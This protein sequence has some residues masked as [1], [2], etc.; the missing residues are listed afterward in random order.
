M[1]D[2]RKYKNPSVGAVLLD[3]YAL[4]T[5]Q[6]AAARHLLTSPLGVTHGY[7]RVIHTYSTLHVGQAYTMYVCMYVRV[8]KTKSK[9]NSTF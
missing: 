5:H 9:S 1:E 6:G 7:A 2:W 4:A 3:A 8:I